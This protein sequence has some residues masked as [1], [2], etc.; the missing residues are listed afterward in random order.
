MADATLRRRKQSGKGKRDAIVVLDFGGQYAHLIAN[1]LRRIG[2]YSEILP[3]D[4]SPAKLKK[5]EH[6]RGLRVKGIILSGGPNSVYAKDAPPFNRKIL[7]MGLPVLGICY[8]HQLMAHTLNGR[9]VSGKVKEYGFADLEVKDR[10][11]ELFKG[12]AKKEV[13]WMSHGDLVEEV[14]EGF[15]VA[16]SS[17]DCYVAAMC[18]PDRK[19]FGVQFH[20]EVTHTKHG[21]KI[22]ENFVRITGAKKS[23]SMEEYLKQIKKE[24]REKAKGRNVFLLV[25]GGVDSTVAFMLLNKVLGQKRVLGLHI[26][27]GFMRKNESAKVLNALKKAG[28]S[29][30][31][32]V[33]ASESFLRAVAGVVEPE[34][35]RRIIG[36]H[37]IRVYRN[38]I[39]ELGLDERHWLMAQG[40]IYPDTIETAGTKNAA[41]IKTHHNRVP[42][43]QRMIKKG[44]VIEPLASLYKDEVRMLGKILGLPAALVDRHPFPGPGLSVRCLCSRADKRIRDAEKHNRRIN[45]IIRAMK[46]GKKFRGFI[47]PVESVGVQGDNRTY[48]HPAV[49]MPHATKTVAINGKDKAELIGSTKL[50]PELLEKV[51][52]ALTNNVHSINR[53]IV[54]VAWKKN[55]DPK[56]FSLKKSTLTRERL[57]LL[58]EADAIATRILRKHRLYSKVWQ[59]P[60]VLVPYG[61]NEKSSSG[62]GE[63][64]VLR[65]VESRE[66]MTARFYP[67]PAKVLK[68]MAV[69]I[70]KLGVDAVFFDVTN[71]PPG[72]IEWE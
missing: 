23:W 66:A 72:T 12:L 38:A 31:N 2:V 16:A 9:V 40:T 56:K 34:E 57:D 62:I 1:R 14:P 65:P 18:N 50:K 69:S 10:K 53:V 26:D 5:E 32:I 13:V 8:G 35:K 60:V 24:I 36:E 33:D 15:H 43:V 48:R 37:F 46:A 52:T 20:P 41:L 7:E 22:L 59:M 6:D 71:K 42:L 70:L 44:L 64:V 28:F 51:S 68:E 63:S 67:L 55:A 21:M 17:S 54:A 29:N 4:V 30:L 61:K 11:C 58:R 19:M 49:I 39:K 3:T 47:A 27:N 25:S 45:G